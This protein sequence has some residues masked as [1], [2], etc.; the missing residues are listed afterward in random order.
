MRNLC[1]LIGDLSLWLMDSLV[2]M[3]RLRCSKACGIF[4]DQGSNLCPLHW[5]VDSE[6]LDHWGSLSYINFKFK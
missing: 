5:Q 2:V 6:P 3:L 1:C 4:Q